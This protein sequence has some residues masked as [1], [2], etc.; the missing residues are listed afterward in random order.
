MFGL[1][2][3]APMMSQGMALVSI[4][5]RLPGSDKEKL[6]KAISTIL[7]GLPLEG[8]WAIMRDKFL[9]SEGSVS[10]RLLGL[11][12]DPDVQGL[13]EAEETLDHEHTTGVVKCRFCGQLQDIE[14]G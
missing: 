8:K 13:L 5:S 12:M 1:G 2:K 11:A 10:G 6:D 4:Y 7:P 14:L 3:F 9:N